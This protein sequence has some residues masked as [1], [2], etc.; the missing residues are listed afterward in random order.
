MMVACATVLSVY[1]CCVVAYA[2]A[3]KMWSHVPSRRCRPLSTARALSLVEEAHAVP[4]AVG[5][6]PSGSFALVP[7]PGFVGIE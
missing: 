2:I 7:P 6:P 3:P 1:P 4:F 5:F